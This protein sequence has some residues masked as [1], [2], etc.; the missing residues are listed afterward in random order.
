MNARFS[1]EL[2]SRKT[3]RKPWGCSTDAIPSRS[4]SLMPSAICVRGEANTPMMYVDA[5]IQISGG[6]VRDVTPASEP[7]QKSFC[8]RLRWWKT[9]SSC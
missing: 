6:Q 3:R 4:D 7:F 5:A 9:S 1:F 2:I 8:G